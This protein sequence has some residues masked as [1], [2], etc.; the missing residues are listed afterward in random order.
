MHE[1]S[2]KINDAFGLMAIKL[3]PVF[4]IFTG[5]VTALTESKFL[6]GAIITALITMKA[7][8]QQQVMLCHPLK[9]KQ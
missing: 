2:E 6:V 7:V 4:D 3:M 1:A 5:I 9:V 8:S